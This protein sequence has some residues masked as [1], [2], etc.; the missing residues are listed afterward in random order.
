MLRNVV[1]E[2]LIAWLVKQL[3]SLPLA[4]GE[5]Q[6]AAFVRWH[7]ALGGYRSDDLKAAATEW[8]RV[9]R[10]VRWPGPEDLLAILTKQRKRRAY[11]P[12]QARLPETHAAEAAMRGWFAGVWNKLPE[13]IGGVFFTRMDADRVLVDV[14][15]PYRT[16]RMEKF[17]V[18][19]ARAWQAGDLP[20]KFRAAVIADV[21]SR[22]AR[23]K[24]QEGQ[25]HETTGVQ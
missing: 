17:M 13:T 24:K 8:M 25:G 2:D 7:N 21:Q 19:C 6:D 1:L 11:Q 12:V 9:Q 20:E 16:G 5:T 14:V 3:G 23:R 18:V 4:E 15:E 10:P 22:V